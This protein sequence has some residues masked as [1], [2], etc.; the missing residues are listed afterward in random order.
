MRLP[1]A[2]WPAALSPSSWPAPAGSGV[3]SDAQASVAPQVQH[4]ALA[5][6][7]IEA[8]ALGA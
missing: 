6:L 8:E 5:D 2:R 4:L 7:R 1:L 3:E